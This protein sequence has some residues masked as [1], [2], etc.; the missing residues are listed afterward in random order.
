L[1]WY[2]RIRKRGRIYLPRY[3]NIPL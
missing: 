3:F 2:I 1:F